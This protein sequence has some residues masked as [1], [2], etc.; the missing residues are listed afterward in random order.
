VGYAWKGIA[1]SLVDA[2]FD[3]ENL[4]CCELIGDLDMKV[5]MDVILHAV[6]A[7][8]VSPADALDFFGNGANECGVEA[9]GIGDNLNSFQKDFVD[10][11]PEK[12]NDADG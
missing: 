6:G 8:G 2:I 7:D 10:C 12:E 5:D 1:Q 4:S 9:S 11:T 3:I